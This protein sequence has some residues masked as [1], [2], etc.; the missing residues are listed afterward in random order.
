MNI[1]LSNVV[2]QVVSATPAEEDW[3]DSILR[4]KDASS[5]FKYNK[6][7]GWIH[8]YDQFEKQFPAG[9]MRQV[10]EKAK[11]SGQVVKVADKRARPCAVDPNADLA[12]LREYQLEA[13]E[14]SLKRT[15]GVLWCPTG[16]GKTEMAIALA[17]SVPC[18]WLFLAH[19]KELVLQAAARYEKR[20]GLKAGVIG[21]GRWDVEQFTAATFQTFNA[22][23][24]KGDVAAQ[25]L[26]ATTE[27]LMIDEVHTLPANSF[28]KVVDAAENAFYRIG[29]SGTPMQRGDEKSMHIIGCTGDVIYRIT[30]QYLIEQGVL[31]KPQIKMMPC[32]QTIELAPM[33]PNARV[34]AKQRGKI[35]AA[36]NKELIIESVERND[37][38]A[39]MIE[40]A[41]KPCLAFVQQLDHG[42]NLEKLVRAAGMRVEF[43]NGNKATPSRLAAVERLERG[44]IDVLICTVIFNEGVDIPELRSV[45]L[46]SAGKS[47][48]AALQRV[49]RGTRK[50]EG[51]KTF[52]VWDVYDKG[53]LLEKQAKERMKAYGIEGYEVEE[54]E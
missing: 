40:S 36:V 41:T 28:K 12:W 33:S 29:L 10:V 25:T 16:S 54:G 22:K 11:A 24:K 38:V 21:D 31:A 32:H 48:I 15:R 51:K 6:G 20:T 19:R 39:G 47:A 46:A 4:W 30:A 34:R 37:L 2:A 26:L 35:W 23:L 27:G 42:K 49:G 45:V 52:E 9:W 1:I 5:R 17:K 13:V 8:L 14:A 44:D 50:V 18:Q 43:V 53:S 7:D 3:L